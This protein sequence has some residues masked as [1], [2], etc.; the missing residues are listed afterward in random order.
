MLNTIKTNYKNYIYIY[1]DI[2]PKISDDTAKRFLENSLYLAIFTSFEFFIKNMISH[3]VSKKVKEKITYMDLNDEI[4]RKYILKNNR[5]NTILNI[6]KEDEQQSKRSF[7]SYLNML[8]TPLSQKDLS[9][10]I[11]FEF[12]HE[13]K[14]NTHYPMIF[15]QIFGTADFLKEIRIAYVPPDSP[16]EQKIYTNALTFI[17]EY[18]QDIRNNIAHNNDHYT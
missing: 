16:I 3:Y 13:S 9:E 4:A 18:C 1:N 7:S 10:H 11:R 6:Y 12:F 5:K 14:L 15:S 8:K 2:I 17:S